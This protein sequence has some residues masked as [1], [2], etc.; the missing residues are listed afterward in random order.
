MKKKIEKPEDRSGLL[1]DCEYIYYTR[2]KKWVLKY[3]D[4]IDSRMT[5][6]IRMDLVEEAQEYRNRLR[7]YFKSL[8]A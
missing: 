4:A 3:L 2:G 7:E 6:A 5:L 1:F 8:Q